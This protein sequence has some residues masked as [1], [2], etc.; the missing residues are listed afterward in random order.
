ML[1]IRFTYLYKKYCALTGK[2]TRICIPHS[3]Y[4]NGCRRNAL[5]FLTDVAKHFNLCALLC[6]WKI[7]IFAQTFIK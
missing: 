3:N 2:M 1:Y 5:K 6:I 7:F 4:I